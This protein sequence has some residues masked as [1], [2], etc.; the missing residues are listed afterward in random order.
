MPSV[1]PA[2][3]TGFG[4]TLLK[5]CCASDQTSLLMFNDDP[6]RGRVRMTRTPVL[7]DLGVA[8]TYYLSCLLTHLR[9]VS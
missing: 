2:A 8:L 1:S 9:E 7:L 4:L 5:T 6:L 3:L